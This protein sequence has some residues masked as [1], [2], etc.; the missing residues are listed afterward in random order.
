MT[1]ERDQITLL[2]S[3]VAR[4]T[5]L[6]LAQ[7]AHLPEEWGLSAHQCTIMGTLLNR[8]VS[9]PGVLLERMYGDE[10]P[11]NS[12]CALRVQITLMRRKL[13]RFG[14]DI[15]SQ[16][17]AGYS[18][19]PYRK[20]II[21]RRLRYQIRNPQRIDVMRYKDQDARREYKRQWQRDKRAQMKDAA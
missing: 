11:A 21:L 1:S 6:L 12:H 9:P 14:I 15:K 20:T 16:R 7:R 4:L 8:D 2:H 19:L 5:G 17:G 10:E 18:L 13:V 3:E